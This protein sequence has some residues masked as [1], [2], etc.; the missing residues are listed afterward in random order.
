MEELAR[1]SSFALARLTCEAE[2]NVKNLPRF[3]KTLSSRDC[4]DSAEGR[5]AGPEAVPA[6]AAVGGGGKVPKE[7]IHSIVT[8]DAKDS[9]CL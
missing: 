9:F 2:N 5:R 4:A 1:R 3:V 6:V 8:N 7:M